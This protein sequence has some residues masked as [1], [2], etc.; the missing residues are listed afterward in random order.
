MPPKGDGRQL[1]VIF[2]ASA[3]ALTGIQAILPALPGLQAAFHLTG[4]QVGLVTSIYLLPSALMAIPLG[5][6]AD[7]IGRRG[8]L[9]GGLLAFGIAGA[10]ISASP[11][12][13][14][15]L[16]ALR[17]IQG[18]GVAAI[19]PLSITV[20]GDLRSGFRQVQ[21]QGHRSVTMF[22]AEA[23]WPLL[24]GGLAVA[25][26][27]HPFFLQTLAI[28]IGLG[29]WVLLP[30]PTRAPSTPRLRGV[31]ALHR[32]PA[33]IALQT[34]GFLRFFF[35]FAFLTY[36]PILLVEE[37]SLTA[38]QVG[39]VLGVTAGTGMVLALLAGRLAKRARASRWMAAALLGYA[40]TFILLYLDLPMAAEL[41]LG[42][43]FGAADGVY[44]VFLNAVTAGAVDSSIR[45]TFVAA[46]GT[47]RSLGKFL[48]PTV[49][50]ILLIRLRVDT[51]FLA[52]G[53][54][55]T[56]TAFLARPL[57]RLDRGATGDPLFALDAP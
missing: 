29:A 54:A 33:V 17:A 26:W 42:A 46:V 48:A 53:V 47:V 23:V 2:L 38:P 27:T 51:A 41:G 36:V 8:V 12:H 35:K 28:A 14:G 43:L 3:V 5:L 40:A 56:G 1:A 4:S 13:F 24:G 57:A 9:A 32:D 55:A 21:A 50:A 6:L 22:I 30:A 39:L 34:A 31:T 44:A 19:L 45:A 11:G 49:L 16:L 20:I 10:W 18:I 52:F 15:T 25:S 37:R 7:R